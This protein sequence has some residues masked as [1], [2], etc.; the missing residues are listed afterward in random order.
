MSAI[1]IAR[2]YSKMTLKSLRL[3]SLASTGFVLAAITACGDDFS[4]PT[5]SDAAAEPSATVLA[6]APSAP[7][8]TATSAVSGEP[9]STPSA[10][11]G[12]ETHPLTEIHG[13]LQGPFGP[14]GVPTTA[15]GVT[16]EYERKADSMPADGPRPYLKIDWNVPLPVAS[17]D[18]KA[19]IALLDRIPDTP[20]N[21]R[22][23]RLGD[24]ALWRSLTGFNLPDADDPSDAF[25]N[26]FMEAIAPERVSEGEQL[27]TFPGQGPFLSGLTDY[28]TSVQTFDAMGFDQRN[29]DQTAVAGVPPNL[30]EVISGRY[31]RELA[32]QLLSE[33]DCPQPETASYGGYEYWIWGDGLQG[34]IMLRLAPPLF[35]HVGRGGY[36]LMTED[37]LYRTLTNPLMEQL[38]DT[39][40]GSV[41]SL[42]ESTDHLFTIDVMAANN[43]T[44]ISFHDGSFYD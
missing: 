23:L 1:S 41:P 26:A 6:V 15:P 3:L 11:D 22:S 4:T 25:I 34:D 2:T 42:S 32:L 9:T 33:C 36:V 28:M 40:N 43:V 18:Q 8:P 39:L 12:V 44:G 16:F 31:D 24:Q 35:D 30:T 27:A 13:D 19:L 10:F 17:D 14:A 20:E 38:I 37:G 7:V 5:P 21:R 29:V